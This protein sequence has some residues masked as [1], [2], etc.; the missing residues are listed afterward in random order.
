MGKT[1]LLMVVGGKALAVA[2]SSGSTRAKGSAG[3]AA[4]A[5]AALDD[6]ANRPE[7][8]TLPSRPRPRFRRLISFIIGFLFEI[9]FSGW[10]RAL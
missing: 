9:Y 4:T 6:A 8:A 10:V 3:A 1:A 5:G 7:A 2:K